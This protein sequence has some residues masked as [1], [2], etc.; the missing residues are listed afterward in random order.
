[1]TTEPPEQRRDWFKT[2]VHSF[3]KA[4]LKYQRPKWRNPG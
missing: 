1:M 2:G 4:K 3:V